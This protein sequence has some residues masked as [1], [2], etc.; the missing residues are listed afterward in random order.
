MMVL[1]AASR[2]E[3]FSGDTNGD[4]RLG[5]SGAVQQSAVTRAGDDESAHVPEVA[6]EILAS[7]GLV[8]LVVGEPD[9]AHLVVGERPSVAVSRPHRTSVAQPALDS[10]EEAVELACRAADLDCGLLDVVGQCRSSLRSHGSDSPPPHPCV[11]RHVRRVLQPNP[12][13]STEPGQLQSLSA[14]SLCFGD[15]HRQPWLS[16]AFP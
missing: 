7:T 12:D 14:L 6:A 5:C 8:D 9:V 13:P 2:M 1:N 11:Y 4:A 15:K 10:P 3:A 16:L